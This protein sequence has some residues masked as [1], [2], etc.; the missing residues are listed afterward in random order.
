LPG[1]PPKCFILRGKSEI[2]L[3]E[4]M[5]QCPSGKCHNPSADPFPLDRTKLP[6]STGIKKF[7][8]KNESHHSVDICGQ[9]ALKLTCEHL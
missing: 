8:S 3:G 7:L 4:A 5:P 9:N 6:P 1:N 2:F